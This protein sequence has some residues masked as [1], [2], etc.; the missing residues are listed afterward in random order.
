MTPS[1]LAKERLHHMKGDFTAF[2]A[3]ANDERARHRILANSWHLGTAI[4]VM[5]MLPAPTD[6]GEPAGV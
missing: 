5:A 6:T 4:L 2:T 1:I 3:P